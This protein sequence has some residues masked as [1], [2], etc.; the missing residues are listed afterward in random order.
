MEEKRYY[1]RFDTKSDMGK[2][3]RRL[4]NRCI[5]ADKA[6]VI[7]QERVGAIA[8][9]PNDAMFA[10]G[11]EG[12]FFADDAKV[13]RE[14]WRE[15]GRSDDGS[16]CWLP[17]CKKREGVLT[18][19]KGA[20]RP[21]DTVTR[22]YGKPFTDKRGHTVVRYIELYRDDNAGTKKAAKGQRKNLPKNFSQSIRTERARL[23]LPTVEVLTLLNRCRRISRAARTTGRCTSCAPSRLRSS[24]TG[25]GLTWASPIP[26]TRRG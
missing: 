14:V 18:L 12:V 21:A 8:H 4:W 23:K 15:V 7:F 25:T 26:A 24:S 2:K 19:P 16:I 17:I 3:F 20:E 5:K 9:C 11:V 1:Y 10:G 22:L 6:R 13:N